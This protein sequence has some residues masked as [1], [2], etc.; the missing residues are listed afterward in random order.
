MAHAR[1]KKP[2]ALCLNPSR[3]SLVQNQRIRFR[4][5]QYG[6]KTISGK[7]RSSPV[8]LPT[9]FSDQHSGRFG[10]VHSDSIQFTA[11]IKYFNV[12][13]SLKIKIVENTEYQQ[14]AKS[15]RL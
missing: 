12:K 1:F 15:P 9:T 2:F 13:L 4:A 7:N 8:V 6:E 3:N 5:G 14:N 10:P 11:A